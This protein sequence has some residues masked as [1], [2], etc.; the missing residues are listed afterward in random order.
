M[1]VDANDLV[2][3]YLDEQAR[4]NFA[5]DSGDINNLVG[6]IAGVSGETVGMTETV[7]TA[8][9]A[10]PHKYDDNQSPYGFVSWG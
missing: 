6:D 7:G 9:T 3:H 2:E 1:S 5:V 10:P 4:I 8:T